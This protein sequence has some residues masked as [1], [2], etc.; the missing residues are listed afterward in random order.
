MSALGSSMLDRLVNTRLDPSGDHCGLALRRPVAP[1]SVSQW[2]FAVHASSDRHVAGTVA[3]SA[4]VASGSPRPYD[5]KTIR[6][7]VGPRLAV[8]R[9][10]T[11][12]RRSHGVSWRR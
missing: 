7:F 6:F 2:I 4:N 8:E 11:S 12:A 3:M 9:S 1:L 5:S 10:K